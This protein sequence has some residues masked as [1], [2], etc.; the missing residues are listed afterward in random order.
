MYKS[1]FQIIFALLILTACRKP[2]VKEFENQEW[3][4]G[5]GQTVFITGVNAYG[6]PFP[7]LTSWHKRMHEIGDFIFES[8]YV[9]APAPKNPGLGPIFNNVSCVSCHIKD[10]R[11]KASIDGQQMAS[12][13]LIR[14]S[15]PGQTQH[16]GPI[17]V[18]LYGG[19]LQQ[20]SIF[21]KQA[22]ADVHVTYTYTTGTFPDGETYELRK[23]TFTLSNFYAGPVAGLLTS[24]RNSPAVFGLGLLEAIPEANILKYQDIND[25]DNDGI[26][27]KANYVWDIYENKTKLGRF[28]WKANTSSLLQ[29][30]ASAFNEDMGITTFL[31]PNESS[32]GQLQYDGLKD[33]PELSDS[34]LH[35]TTFYIQTLAVP[36]RRNVDDPQVKRG[37]QIFTDAKCAKCHVPSHRTGVNV[38]F[39]YLSNQLIFP[40]TDL[41]LH[42]MGVELAD[43]RPDFLADGQEWRTPPLWGIGLSAVVNGHTDFL[44]DGRAR[45]LKEAILWHGGEAE[46]SKNYFIQLSKDD[47]EALI[48]FLNS[49]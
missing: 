12:G 45:N 36:G 46:D 1:V 22:E 14:L 3:F 8:T 4:S 30:V 23:P 15:V 39:T 44:H 33:D 28:G 27:G 10:G 41:L 5:G 43:N 26:S 49:L 32:F 29:Q 17:P 20:R 42:D 24:P 34:L 25:A 13:T 6:E 21:G 7:T 37:K 40:Y 9:S 16:G 11:G 19:Q 48:K 47:R 38:V 2:Q 31:F 18:P 35:L